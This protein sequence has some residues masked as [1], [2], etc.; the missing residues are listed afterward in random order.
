MVEHIR[1]QGGIMRSYLIAVTAA[2][3]LIG[4]VA[5][6]PGATGNLFAA[7]GPTA[8]SVPER[9]WNGGT[10]AP[11]VVSAPILDYTAT[12][13]G[14][15]MAPIVVSA[16]PGKTAEQCVATQRETRTRG[17]RRA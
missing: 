10:L 5:S 11:I 3:A 7:V 12:W 8:P 15:V 14:G 2:V 9:V 17:H 16:D 1:Y 4:V 6:R 13:Y